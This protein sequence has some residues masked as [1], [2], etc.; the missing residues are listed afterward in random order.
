MVTVTLNICDNFVNTKEC[1]IVTYKVVIVVYFI[2]V[3]LLTL[4]FFEI[5]LIKF[6]IKRKIIFD[7]KHVTNVF[8]I[9]THNIFNSTIQYILYVS[10][11]L[12]LNE[13]LI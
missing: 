12:P 9:V 3:P 2:V 1:E 4:M 11:V 8:I 6:V 10:M 13:N 7:E 5:V